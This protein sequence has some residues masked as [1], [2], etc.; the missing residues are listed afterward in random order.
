MSRR[1]WMPLYIGDYQADTWHLSTYEHG[2]YLLLLMHI[3]STTSCP[4]TM[5]S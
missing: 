2:A 4:V 5:P 1:P 3:G